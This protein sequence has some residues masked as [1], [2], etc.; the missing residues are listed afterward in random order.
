MGCSSDEGAS[1]SNEDVGPVQSATARAQHKPTFE[2]GSVHSGTLGYSAELSEE[3]AIQPTIE[4]PEGQQ[5]TYV[6]SGGDG[7]LPASIT[8]RCFRAE[9]EAARVQTAL[10]ETRRAF[11]DVTPGPSR[12]VQGVEAISVR[13][14]AGQPPLEVEREDVVFA[15]DRCAWF[16]SFVNSPGQRNDRI[17]EFDRFLA[18]FDANP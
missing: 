5:D 4:L 9:D 7:K 8:V 2:E 13:Y 3:W 11:K 10:A 1:G 12:R 16:I 15:T 18:T 14:T 6:A 17:D